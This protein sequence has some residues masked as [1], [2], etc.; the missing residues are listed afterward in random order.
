MKRQVQASNPERRKR[1]AGEYDEHQTVRWAKQLQNKVGETFCTLNVQI[2]NCP[3]F[4]IFL[5]I[6]LLKI[7]RRDY[8]KK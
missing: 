4:V 7:K 2:L 5:E 1:L 3:G 6:R 8:F